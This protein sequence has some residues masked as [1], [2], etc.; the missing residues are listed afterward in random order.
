MTNDQHLDSPCHATCRLDERQI[1]CLSCG[2]TIAEIRAWPTAD[3]NRKR[4]ILAR[5]ARH[6][7]ATGGK[8][9]IR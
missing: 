4:A 9:Q 8:V 5:L 7:A 2:R 1:F 3:D 6:E